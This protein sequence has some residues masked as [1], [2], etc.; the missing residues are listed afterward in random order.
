M[1]LWHDVGGCG[2]EGGE[3]EIARH[4]GEVGGST[5]C[6]YKDL[7]HAWVGIHAGGV[8]GEVLAAGAGVEY[9]GIL[10]GN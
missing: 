9:C 3:E 4:G 7:M 2:W 6:S 8:G 1:E 10:W 5:C